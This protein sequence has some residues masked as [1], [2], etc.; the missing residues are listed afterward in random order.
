MASTARTPIRELRRNCESWKQQEHTC[1]G[2]CCNQHSSQ[3]QQSR[4]SN[5]QLKDNSRTLTHQ[6]KSSCLTRLIL[7]PSSATQHASQKSS[8]T[9]TAAR[10]SNSTSTHVIRLRTSPPARWR[11]RSSNSP[12]TSRTPSS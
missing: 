4:C 1:P 3:Q 6:E 7:A 5:R 9:P 2:Q 11:A 8:S 12:A 10:R